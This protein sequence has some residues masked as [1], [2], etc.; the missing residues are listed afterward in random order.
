MWERKFGSQQGR[1][2]G[3]TAWKRCQSLR[4]NIKCHTSRN[5]QL[6]NTGWENDCFDNFQKRIWRT[7]WG[8]HLN[9][10]VQCYSK[11]HRYHAG[12]DQQTHCLTQKSSPALPDQ[13]FWSSFWHRSRSRIWMTRSTGK[14]WNNWSHFIQRKEVS[15]HLHIHIMI[16]ARGKNC[17]PMLKSFWY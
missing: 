13:A 1:K 12:T 14:G 6:R 8:S 16:Y 5:N 17:T 11:R 4:T 2:A 10:E 3:E 7:I 15:A 9:G